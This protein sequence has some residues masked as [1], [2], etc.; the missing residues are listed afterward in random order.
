MAICQELTKQLANPR[1]VG[2]LV[3]P[4]NDVGE[5]DGATRVALMVG[6]AIRTGLSDDVLDQKKNA[7]VFPEGVFDAMHMMHPAYA[8][9]T[10][11]R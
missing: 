3:S 6:S 4:E 7:E 2:A 5:W 8:A 1:R 9:L 11:Y 10:N